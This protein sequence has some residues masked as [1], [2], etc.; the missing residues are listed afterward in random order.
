VTTDRDAFAAGFAARAPWATGFRVGGCH[1]GGAYVP[2]DDGRLAE[3]CRLHPAPGRV[4]ELGSLEGG[5]SFALAGRGWD[6]VAV[7]GR[8]ASL[9]RAAWL[10]GA[11]FPGARVRFVPG[12]V[13]TLDLAGLGT[14][15]AV[16]CVG[17][18]YHLPEPW[19]LLRRLHALAPVLFVCTHFALTDEVTAGGYRGRWYAEHGP[20]DP[21]SGLEPRSFWPTRP[22]VLRMVADT[23]WGVRRLDVLPCPH[24]DILLLDCARAEA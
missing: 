16:F 2:A 20:G 21:L 24:G 22:E 1:Y 13:R 8:P 23:G 9:A 15:D 4:L 11:A 3:F 12:D 6:V 5:H 17:L 18:L 14:F 7:E 19:E 10:H